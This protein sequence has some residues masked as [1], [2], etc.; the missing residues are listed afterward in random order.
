MKLVINDLELNLVPYQTEFVD[1]IT[2]VLAKDGVIELKL[3][4]Q[5]LC[6]LKAQFDQNYQNL[7]NLLSAYNQEIENQNIPDIWKFQID[8]ECTTKWLEY[9]H[10]HWAMLTI[11]DTN[12]N[13]R[14]SWESQTEFQKGYYGHANKIIKSLSGKTFDLINHMVH[15]NEHLAFHLNFDI[16]FQGFVQSEIDAGYRVTWQDTSFE[17]SA[18]H[19]MYYDVGRPQYEKWQLGRDLQSS[20]ISNYVHISDL[21]NVFARDQWA[22]IDQ[23]YIKDCQS[24]GVDCWKPVLPFANFQE[25]YFHVGNKILRNISEH[26]TGYIIL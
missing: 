17:K 5:Q 23:E 1:Y 19:F 4:D 7:T 2:S 9:V 18:I 13:N 11:R 15:D 24:A 25:S 20:E 12:R 21:A 3:I 10:E 16:L 8:T 22:K 6:D 26:N 14:V